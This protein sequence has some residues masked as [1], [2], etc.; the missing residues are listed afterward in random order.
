[1]THISDET[2]TFPIHPAG[3]CQQSFTL[4]GQDS[5]FLYRLREHP[6][7]ANRV[8]KRKDV[9]LL[10]DDVLDRRGKVSR[11]HDNAVCESEG[12]GGGFRHSHHSVTVLKRYVLVS[13]RN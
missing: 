13:F 11:T 12:L 1:M 10:N 8:L 2:T 5:T 7:K 9:F 4:E 6:K 3:N